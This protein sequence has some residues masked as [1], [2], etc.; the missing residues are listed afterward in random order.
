MIK[1]QAKLRQDAYEYDV[2]LSFAKEDDRYVKKVAE[3]LADTD[4]RVFY[5]NNEIVDLWGK[6]LYSYLNDI[7]RKKARYSVLF[8][9]KYYAKNL[10]TNQERKSAQARAFTE[11]EEYILPVRF[12][13]T[14]RECILPTISYI[15]LKKIKPADLA[16][17]IKQKLG[18]VSRSNF[19]PS[20][21]EQ[22]F[23]ELKIKN[24]N[25]KLIS[26]AAA[27]F[28][29][30]NLALMTEEERRLVWIALENCCAAG[31]PDNIHLY[32]EYYER[33]TKKTKREIK[34]IFSRLNF[35]SFKSRIHGEK[36]DHEQ[37][38]ILPA[39]KEKLEIKFQPIFVTVKRNLQ[40]GKNSTYVLF[41]LYNLL[42]KNYCSACAIKAFMRVDLSV[43][44]S[45]SLK[46]Q[47]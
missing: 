7:Y 32:L 14:E 4:L 11:N 17:L 18:Q 41:A 36:Y 19:F 6:N 9:S 2:A 35:L 42:S 29:F 1:N 45:N 25:G 33:L 5:A 12:D 46:E 40:G 44:N 31:E 20:N 8:L 27:N 43:L 38:N 34:S 23:K 21:I 22:L 28:L 15:N 47:S 10:W 39:A 3:A 24:Q 26:G 16:E 13:K 30:K 37:G